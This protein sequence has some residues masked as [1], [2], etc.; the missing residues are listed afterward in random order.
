MSLKSCSVG[1][2]VAVSDGTNGL[3][4]I[5]ALSRELKTSKNAILLSEQGFVTLFPIKASQSPKK[6][7]GILMRRGEMVAIRIPLAGN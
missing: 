7:D 3:K 6:P 4:S 5:D 1:Y 2:F